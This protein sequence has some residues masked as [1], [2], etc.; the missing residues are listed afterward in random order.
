MDGGD[1][2]S[3]ATHARRSSSPAARPPVSG[4]LGRR[5]EA[6]RRGQNAVGSVMLMSFARPDVSH[7]ELIRL[8]SPDEVGSHRP[9]QVRARLVPPGGRGGCDDDAG[10]GSP[11]AQAPIGSAG[12]HRQ[13]Q[14]LGDCCSTRHRRT[15]HPQPPPAPAEPPQRPPGAELTKDG[16]SRTPRPKLA[17]RNDH[18]R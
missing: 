2:G 10:A 16:T 17:H 7:P 13:T 15:R 4:A 8:G 6:S 12:S 18:S 3:S 11:L 1:P 9:E 5:G 14:E